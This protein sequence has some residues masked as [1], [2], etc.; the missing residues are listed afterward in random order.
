MGAARG[1]HAVRSAHLTGRG[2]CLA[3]YVN[4]AAGHRARYVRDVGT[5]KQRLVTGFQRRVLNPVARPAARLLPGY[6]VIETIGRSSGLPR[7]TPVGGRREGS[8]FWLVSEF[9][10]RSNYIRNIAA[11]PRVRLRLGHQWYAGSAS[12]LEDDDPRARLRKLGTLNSLMVRAVGQELLTVR[13]D[14]DE[15]PAS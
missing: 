9:G 1:T 12:L 15:T 3:G 10:H 4:C 8:T 7:Q 5:F 11:N 14:L 2:E 6:A 13:I